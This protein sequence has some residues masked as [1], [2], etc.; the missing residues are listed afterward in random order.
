S[1]LVLETGRLQD[2]SPTLCPARTAF[3]APDAPDAA[4]PR[5]HRLSGS[6]ELCPERLQVC[7]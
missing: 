3:P 1:W 6:A 2:S 4:G 5:L 7:R